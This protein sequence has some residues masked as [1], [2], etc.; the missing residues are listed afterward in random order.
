MWAQIFARTYEVLEICLEFTWSLLTVWIYKLRTYFSKLMCILK[1][2]ISVLP[3]WFPPSM[4]ST[5]FQSSSSYFQTKW[6]LII[7]T[8][9][10]FD[11]HSTHVCLFL[12]HCIIAQSIFISSHWSVHYV[13]DEILLYYQ[14]EGK[15]LYSVMNP[16]F[17]SCFFF[18]SNFQEGFGNLH[19]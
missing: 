11:R 14:S 7:A 19:L 9:Y 10:S 12:F 4:S 13:N 8:W 5:H 2:W 16:A 17:L 6:Y 15:V 1:W 18:S 3:P